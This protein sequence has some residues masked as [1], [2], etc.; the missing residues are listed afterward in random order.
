M[1]ALFQVLLPS[2]MLLHVQGCSNYLYRGEIDA[3]NSAEQES[4]VI[5]YWTKTDKL[6]GQPKAGPAILMTECSTRRITFVEADSGIVFYGD[7]GK[8]VLADFSAAVTQHTICGRIGNAAQFKNLQAGPVKVDIRCKA[9][10]QGDA[11]SIASGPFTPAYLKAQPEPY[12]FEIQ[13][14][15]GWSLFGAIPEVPVP[16]ACRN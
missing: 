3:V 15:S 5:L 9:A 13:E 2:L 7:P 8:D 11:F 6:F 16:P 14:S 4:K 10:D 12:T 1:K